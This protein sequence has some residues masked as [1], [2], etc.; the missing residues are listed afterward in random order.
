MKKEVISG[1][2]GSPS[3]PLYLFSVVLTTLIRAYQ[4]YFGSRNYLNS[5]HGGRIAA[6]RGEGGQTL[7][8]S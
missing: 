2:I 1:L 4:R 7:D 5:E 6:N 3:P 8:A